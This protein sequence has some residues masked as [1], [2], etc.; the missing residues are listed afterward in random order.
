MKLE[1]SKS[2]MQNAEINEY[3]NKEESNDEK[4]ISIVWK[5]EIPKI[6]LEAN[7]SEGTT[8]SILNEYIGHFEDTKK[9][10]GNIGLAA[11]NRGYKVNY[12]E[13]L[14]NL[15]LGDE[16]I[17]TYGE[18]IRKYKVSEKIIIKDYDW[19]NL[20]NTEENRLTLITCLENEPEF[21]RCIKAIEE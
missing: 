2:A 10:T 16:I 5:L 15:E 11:H 13:K 3:L 4:N 17:Y 18:I 9:D 19:T 7:I 8:D 20:E 1:E 12:F 14:K 21:R 6:G